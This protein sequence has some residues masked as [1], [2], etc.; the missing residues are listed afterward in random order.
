MTYLN[1]GNSYTMPIRTILWDLTMFEIELKFLDEIASDKMFLKIQEN[2]TSLILER[3]LTIQA[4][5][6]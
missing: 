5:T 2:S 1:E 6:L 4:I 3:S